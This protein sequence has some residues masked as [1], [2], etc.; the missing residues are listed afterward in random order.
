[1]IHLQNPSIDFFG[2]QIDEPV[3]TITDLIVAAVGI[4][5][6][7]KTS[8]KQ[9]EKHISYY[10][11]FFL[12]TGVSTL[13]AAILGHA[14]NYRFGFEA[15][16]PGWILGIL[17]VGFA[18]LAVLYNTR[19]IIGNRFFKPLLIINYVEVIS[20][21]ILIVVL[22]SF[23]LVEIHSAFGLLFMVTVLEIINYRKTKS[24]LSK[25]MVWGVVLAVTAVICHIS[26][27]AFSEW[28]NHL[29]ISHLFMALSLYV[30]YK[31]VCMEQEQI[32]TQ[33]A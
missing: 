3:S 9:N 15:K 11:Y 17:G 16:I 20:V 10:R 27:L 21:L 14:F 4:M 5:G 33:P 13:F 29:D 7:F 26:K 12:F 8:S 32:K 2:L 19:D 22:R 1:M 23:V 18:Q 30:M 6:F 24:P 25:N 28:F 31:G